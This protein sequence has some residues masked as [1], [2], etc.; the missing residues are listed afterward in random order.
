MLKSDVGELI[1]T[2]QAFVDKIPFTEGFKMKVVEAKRGFVKLSVDPQRALFNHFGTYQAGVY[3]TAAEITGGLLCGTFLDLLG[4]L[5]ITQK[6]SIIFQ[7]ATS[8]PL[9]V[10]AELSEEVIDSKI[11]AVLTT[12]RKTT[13]A[14]DVFVK[15]QGGQM[16]AQCQNDYYLRVGI[17]KIFIPTNRP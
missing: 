3:F 10:T 17:P 2:L 9:I 4:H 15:T 6:S 1:R 13:L 7:K 11:V 14:V 5:L 12:Q 16:V 8:E